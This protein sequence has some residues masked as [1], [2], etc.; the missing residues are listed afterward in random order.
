MASCRTWCKTETFSTGSTRLRIASGWFMPNHRLE[1]R[2]KSWNTWRA[3]P[4]AYPDL[5]SRPRQ[6]ILF[7]QIIRALYIG[8]E[9]LP[10]DSGKVRVQKKFKGRNSIR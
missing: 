10:E 6:A 8:L 2:R 5:R 7:L 9:A 3:I 4:T 1:G